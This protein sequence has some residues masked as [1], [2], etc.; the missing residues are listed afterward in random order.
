LVRTYPRLRE[1]S[2]VVHVRTSVPKYL[3]LIDFMLRSMRSG[4]DHLRNGAPHRAAMLMLAM[5]ALRALVPA[6][7]MLTPI[8]GRLAVVLCD[9]DVARAARRHG[10]QD[11]PGH[12][13]HLQLDQTCPYAQSAGPAPLPALPAFGPQP[14]V[15]PAAMPAHRGQIYA[16]CGPPRQQS[17]RAPPHL[18]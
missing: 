4:A 16:H 6:G 10:G 3:S 1:C 13:H 2:P 7:F 8:D 15:S 18:A 14:V 17:P 12:H 11:Y 9:T 5:L